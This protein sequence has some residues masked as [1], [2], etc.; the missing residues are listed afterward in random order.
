MT[1]EFVPDAASRLG[2]TTVGR[3]IN[4]GGVPGS[5]PGRVKCFSILFSMLV[6]LPAKWVMFNV[7]GL[8]SL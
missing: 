1:P 6:I 8:L 5:N 7:L 2:G 3:S 4:M